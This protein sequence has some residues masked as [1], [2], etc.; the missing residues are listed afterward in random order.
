MKWP[1]TCCNDGHDKLVFHRLAELVGRVLEF[2]STYMN[3]KPLSDGATGSANRLTV[4]M[5]AESSLM[6]SWWPSGRQRLELIITECPKSHK[7]LP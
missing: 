5:S 3:N 1:V 6:R 2:P 7:T 4:D